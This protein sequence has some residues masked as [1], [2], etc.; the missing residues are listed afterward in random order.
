[1]V[2]VHALPTKLTF[3]FSSWPSDM[4]SRASRYSCACDLVSARAWSCFSS[5]NPSL[6]PSVFLVKF[7]FFSWPR[8]YRGGVSR[9]Y[10]RALH[11]FFTTRGVYAFL[12]ARFRFIN[13]FPV[14]N[15]VF[16]FNFYNI[17]HFFNPVS[18]FSFS[19]SS[20]SCFYFVVSSLAR[21]IR[22]LAAP[23]TP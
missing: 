7:K 19:V 9:L 17:T 5:C 15:F 12:R 14:V 3:A 11:I 10:A 2:S 18:S 16:Q 23:R 13:P 21:Q 20:S 4:L 22:G 1:M 8:L 6:S